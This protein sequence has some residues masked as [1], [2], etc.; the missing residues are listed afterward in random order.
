MVVDVGWFKAV[1]LTFASRLREWLTGDGL[2]LS[3]SCNVGA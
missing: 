2:W 3:D 1:W